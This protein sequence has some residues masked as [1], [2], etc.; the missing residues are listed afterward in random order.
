MTMIAIEKLSLNLGK[1]EILK[2]ISLNAD[3]GLIGLIGPNGAG[4]SSL[5]KTMAGIWYP[6]RGRILLNNTPLQSLSLDARRRM[7]AYLPQHPRCEWPLTVRQIISLSLQQPTS[8]DAL[9]P[10]YEYLGLNDLMDRSFDQL[11]GGQ[12]QRVMLARVFAGD[13]DIAL[14]DEPVAAQDP[15]WQ[16]RVMQ[17]LASQSA[18]RCMMIAIHDMALATR[19]CTHLAVM[20]QGFIKLFDV[21]EI[22]VKSGLISDVFGVSVQTIEEDGQCCSVPWHLQDASAPAA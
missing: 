4:K 5:L 11:S 2:Q 9:I 8:L 13:P 15:S 10:I 3:I 19:Y 21:K 18:S 6:T 16:L 7:L 14:L 17:W 1:H 22:V 12:Q 20:D